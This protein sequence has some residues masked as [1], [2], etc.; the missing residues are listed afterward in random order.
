MTRYATATRIETWQVPVG[1][2]GVLLTDSPTGKVV[3]FRAIVE[4]D[5][6][7]EWSLSPDQLRMLGRH[8]D[9]W[10]KAHVADV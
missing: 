5:A 2:F 4:F 9:A 8:I 6:I 3:A 7:L 10:R 1:E